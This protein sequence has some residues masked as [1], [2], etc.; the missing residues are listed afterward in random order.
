M[1][2]SRIVATIYNAAEYQSFK[3]REANHPKPDVPIPTECG[4][5]LL[6]RALSC[7]N[8]T[9]YNPTGLQGLSEMQLHQRLFNQQFSI[10]NYKYSDN[11]DRKSSRQNRPNKSPEQG[12]RGFCL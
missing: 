8:V 4:W 3:W 2:C 5:C 7:C 9:P 10:E 11:D 6:V 1:P 12:V